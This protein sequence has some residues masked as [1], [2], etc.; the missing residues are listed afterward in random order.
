MS[1]PVAEHA[2]FHIDGAVPF[3]KPCYVERPAD[4]QLRDLA[5][6]GGLGYV[7]T[8]SQMGKTSLLFHVQAE[9]RKLRLPTAYLD[10]HRFGSGAGVA[11]EPWCR[12]F[13]KVLA[14]DLRLGVDV[15][16]W[17]AERREF[18]PIDRLFS[19]IREELG[20]AT[21]GG[22]TPGAAIFIDE[23]GVLL[24]LAF[25]DDFI[26][27]LRA[28]YQ[29]F[30]DGS[31]GRDGPRNRV[32]V[33][34]FG[35][36][37]PDQL[38]RDGTATRFNVGLRLEL[39]NLPP[40]NAAPLLQGLPGRQQAIL[41][42][43][44]GWTNGHPYLTQRVCLA[45]AQDETRNWDGAAV[46][47]VI[48]WL[49]L[50]PQAAEIDSNLSYVRDALLLSPDKDEL[51]ALYGAIR[52]GR[53][54]RNV[55]RSPLHRQLRGCGL[56]RPDAHGRLVVAN[57]IYERVFDR[58]WV[59]ANGA[60]RWWRAVPRWA[61]VMLVAIII[62]AVLLGM[63]AVRIDRSER[64]AAEQQ[65][66]AQ[67]RRL[68]AESAPLLASHYDLALLLGLAAHNAQPTGQTA[69]YL[70]YTLAANPYIAAY[71]RA[72]DAPVNV[73][74]FAP[75]GSLFASGDDAGDIIVWDAAGRAPTPLALDGHAAPVNGLAF[76]AD[77]SFLASASCAEYE[78]AT[79]TCRRGEVAL[80]S[81]VGDGAPSARWAGH[82]DRAGALALSADNRY[83]A[84]IGGGTLLVWDVAAGTADD[85]QIVWEYAPEASRALTAVAFSPTDAGRL[86][87]GGAD[88]AI[89]IIDVATGAVVFT[90]AAHGEAVAALAF[91]PDG[92]L[93]A[94]AGRDGAVA[95]WQTNSWEPRLAPFAAHEAAV[96]NLAYDDAGRLYSL[97]ADGMIYGWAAGATSNAPT[98]AL[99]GQ[100]DAGWAL[101]AADT[102]HG[103]ALLSPGG[104][105]ALVWWSPGGDPGRG[106]WLDGRPGGVLGLAYAPDG[107]L[108]AAGGDGEIGLWDAA[109]TDP[110]AAAT[111]AGHDGPVRRVAFAP[112]GRTLASV[113]RD[114]R[115]LLWDSA[116]PAAPPRVLGQHEAITRAVA[117]A[118][119]GARLATADDRGIIRLWDTVTGEPVGEPL[120]AHGREIFDLAYSPDG[121]LLASGSWDGT[122][123]FWDAATLQP[124]GAPVSTGLAEVWDVAFSPDGAL[125]AVAGAGEVAP[126]IDVAQRVV[127][128]RLLTN[129]ATRINTLAFSPDGALLATGGADATVALWDMG[130]RTPI[131]RPLDV[132]TAEIYALAFSPDGRYL[133]SGDLGGRLFVTTVAYDDPAATACAVAG[134]DLTDEERQQYADAAAPVVTGCAAAGGEE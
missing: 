105:N 112:D 75:G 66:A 56:V 77:S 19:F 16:A 11:V 126:L 25:G 37:P 95:Q 69:A 76:A 96:F 86:A 2:F 34:L 3:D 82:S 85:G 78:T 103:R 39:G 18:T 30:G 94:S 28:L 58:R 20:G 71:L 100:G 50:E 125:L 31:A 49:F 114:G 131:G 8:A 81:L 12:S 4:L 107:R 38:V 73:V 61:W 72:H 84:S 115:V 14:S 83:L 113:G 42:H 97:G 59:S 65:S 6:R 122:V 32:A 87:L 121:A 110:A 128:G 27:G 127:V 124:A 133:A 99:T 44:F 63:A 10:L 68:M 57:R 9:L 92:R 52:R 101:A 98:L 48:R 36:L 93:L 132:H 5:L 108:A 116:A 129:Q 55:E 40:A 91:S 80:W 21:L 29:S 35:M 13:L 41:E 60:F 26:N 117:V 119:D 120:Q 102:P 67:A 43:V 45:I 109:T 64:L 118:P 22:A 47:D 1:E 134:R 79:D 104:D 70:R 15:S 106:H 54:V 111:L 7:L 62:M 90:F 130:T 123:A 23:I 33:V 24:N 17:W 89:T 74:A 53:A 51:I 88:G 46:Q